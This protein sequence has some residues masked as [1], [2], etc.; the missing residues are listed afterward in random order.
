MQSNVSL[1][2]VA[3]AGLAL[4]AL[5]ATSGCGW[6]RRGDEL[7]GMAP[8]DRPLEVPPEMGAI[9]TAAGAAPTGS[10]TASGAVAAAQ[11][12]RAADATGFTVTGGDRNAVYQAVD[13]I[14]SGMDGVEI[15]SR[16]ELLGAFD[17]Q[18]Q[19]AAFLVR[20]TEG[21]DGVR[22]SAVDPRGAPATGPEV[23]ALMEALKAGIG[24]NSGIGAN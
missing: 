14:L 2:R 8:Q 13:G 5:V 23:E 24:A 21:A 10:V 20:V 9:D 3:L 4:G 16:A 6:F 19:G 15:G 17:L 22:V 11:Q 12:A 1:P 18:Y 7:Y